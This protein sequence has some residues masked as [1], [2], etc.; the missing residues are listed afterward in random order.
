MRTIFALLDDYA[1]VR[2]AVHELRHAGIEETEL[3]L[4]VRDS[5]VDNYAGATP[6][7]VDPDIAERLGGTAAGLE[8]LFAERRPEML[9]DVGR[10]YVVGQLASIVA[11]T[12]SRPGLAEGALASALVDVGVAGDAARAYGDGVRRGDVLLWLRVADERA[13]EVADL[14]RLRHGKHVASYGAA[15]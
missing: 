5:T 8:G 4:I 9:P 15:G 13:G 1:E 6:V 12:A 14:L 11:K 3:N 2:T 7:R 10:V